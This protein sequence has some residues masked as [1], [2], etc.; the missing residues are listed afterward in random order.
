[1]AY[2][3]VTMFEI[4]EVL[5]L[6]LASVPKKQIARL[7][8]LSPKTVRRY[9]AAAEAQ[10]LGADS[11]EASLTEELFAVILLQ[12]EPKH[13]RPHGPTWSV[14]QEHRDFIA[15]HLSHG[16]RLTKV[17][18]LLLRQ[19]VEIPY[20]TLHR[21]A[22][23]EL[24]F[25]RTAA[26]IPVADG[27]PGQEVQLDTGWMTY[28]E[29]D[30]SGRRRRLRA[31]IFTPNVSR[32]RF[33]YPCFQETTR[34]A[35]EA[36]EAA[37]AFYGG[38]FSVVIPD[39]TKAIVDR[40][41]P[42]DPRINRTFLEYSQSRGFHIDPTRVRSPRDKPRV[43]RSVSYVR[44]DCFTGE[45]LTT[46]EQALARA[47]T[48]SRDEAGMRRCRS[49]QRLPR[50]HFEAVE[51]P[52]LLPV[53][54]EPYD[55]P[56]WYEPKVARDQ[57]ANVDKALY[58]LPNDYIGHQL[59]ARAD[60]HLVR[61]Y[62]KHRLIKTHPRQAPGHRAIDP[63]DYPAHKT[64]YALRD[65]A[66]LQRLAAE[67]GEPIGRYATALL[68]TD[69]PW[70]RMRQVYALLGLVK[71]YGAE[72]VAPACEKALDAEIINTRRLERIITRGAT[73]AAPAPASPPAQ[74]ISLGRYLRPASQFAIP[75]TH[76]DD[77]TTTGG[78]S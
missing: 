63:Q 70:T 31:W 6:W 13:E 32:Y 78:D 15:G 24:E 38:V 65:V 26:T 8:G 55:V 51:L 9:I 41:D 74:V 2:R 64:A 40:S 48:W 58:S 20:A 56:T 4:K 10:G 35:V 60:S 45:R 75:F 21:F 67:H 34:I 17:R 25:G 23:A 66:Y 14:C 19:G 37:W 53:P 27:E 57:L 49:T 52:H 11:T 7:Q 46:I 22:V 33:V 50:E 59:T 5:R 71:R 47:L 36:C 54:A 43:E 29:T 16:V 72:R 61:F 18:R 77:S 39:N 30:M 1:M 69:L 76:D 73:P 28:L 44:D 42:L 12:L 62:D 3:E 68:D